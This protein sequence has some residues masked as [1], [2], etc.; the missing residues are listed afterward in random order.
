MEHSDELAHD[1]D[2]LWKKDILEQRCRNNAPSIFG[3][4]LARGREA[5]NKVYDKLHEAYTNGEISES[6]YIQVDAVDLLWEGKV[7]TTQIEIILVIEISWK[8]AMH[9]V[10]RAIARAK[11]LQQVGFYALPVV[12]GRDWDEAA[13]QAVVVQVTNGSVKSDSWSLVM[14]KLGVIR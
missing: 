13:K 14:T 8:V 3:R 6:Q 1:L 2:D 5:T 11:I 4:Y 7:R 10:E 12:I 9:D